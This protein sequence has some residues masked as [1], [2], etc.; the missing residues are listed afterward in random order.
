MLYYDVRWGKDKGMRLTPH[1]FRNKTFRASRGK[2]GPHMVV[3]DE[4]ELLHYIREGWSVRMSNSKAGHAP[5][6]ISP[7]SLQGWK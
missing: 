5:S 2:F 7:D 4:S 3:Q 6:L 1:C